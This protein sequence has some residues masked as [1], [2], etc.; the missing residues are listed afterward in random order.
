MECQRSCLSAILGLGLLVLA[1]SVA[2][3]HA[4]VYGIDTSTSRCSRVIESDVVALD[5]PYFWNRLGAV[6]PHGMVFALQRDVVAAQ[7]GTHP[8]PGNAMLREGKR[9][10]PL[11]LRM[12][13]GDCLRVQLINWLNPT[14]VDEE[15]VAT[16]DVSLRAIGLELYSHIMDDGS[17]VGANAN[18]LTPPGGS[19]VYVWYA[20]REGTYL[21]Y[22]GGALVGGEG[23]NGCGGPLRSRQRGAAGLGLVP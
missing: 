21:L 22:N 19:S 2:P 6:Q 23:D 5:Q 10:R 15:Q 4:A 17:H 11:V 13:V 8:G 7:S 20:E 3:A 14:P 9:P 18:S 16:R 12:N 1:V